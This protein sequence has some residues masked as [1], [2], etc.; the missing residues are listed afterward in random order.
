MRGGRGRRGAPDAGSAT[1]LPANAA[2]AGSDEKSGSAAAL[3]NVVRAGGAATSDAPIVGGRT[4]RVLAIKRRAAADSRRCLG[5][6]NGL[7]ELA[8]AEGLGVAGA[9][10]AASARGAFGRGGAGSSMHPPASRLHARQPSRR[11]QRGNHNAYL[12][13][14]G[15]RSDHRRKSDMRERRRRPESWIPPIVEDFLIAKAGSCA[16][17]ASAL[18]SNQSPAQG[19]ALLKSGV[20]TGIRTSVA[21]VK[22]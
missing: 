21:T 16:R 9:R 3:A 17:L 13:K 4:P 11:R 5:R 15:T 1:S 14:R 8:E 18:C 12:A 6:A 22:G 10:V 19:R 20:P 7:G 2:T